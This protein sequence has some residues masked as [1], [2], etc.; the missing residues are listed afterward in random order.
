MSPD[1]ISAE[2]RAA[3]LGAVVGVPLALPLLTEQE[4]IGL[5]VAG[6]VAGYLTPTDADT[7]AAGARAGLVAAVPSTVWFFR[8]NAERFVGYDPVMLAIAGGV[9]TAA[10]ILV[11]GYLAGGI[12]AGIGG[13][14]AVQFGRKEPA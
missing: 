5:L 8:T 14:L 1:D 11:V 10:L 4:A 9:V 7:Y 2:W 6:V 3:L 12:G 13:W